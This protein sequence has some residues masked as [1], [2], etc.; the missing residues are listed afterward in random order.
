MPRRLHHHGEMSDHSLLQLTKRF[1]E[2]TTITP[3]SC[4]HQRHVGGAGGSYSCAFNPDVHKSDR[5]GHRTSCVRRMS[6]PAPRK[7]K[8]PDDHRRHPVEE[9]Y[10]GPAALP[11]QAEAIDEQSARASSWTPNFT[12]VDTVTVTDVTMNFL[13]VTVRESSTATGFFREKR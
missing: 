5:G 8:H 9:S 7:P 12:N 6:I 11:T 1:Q 10:P 13:T 3:K 2:E 4:S